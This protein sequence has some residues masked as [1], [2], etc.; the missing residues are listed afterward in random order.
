MEQ[1]GE[2]RLVRKKY[3]DDQVIDV[4]ARLHGRE[5]SVEEIFNIIGEITGQRDKV[6][7]AIAHAYEGVGIS[8]SLRRAE[9]I[10]EDAYLFLLSSE[11]GRSLKEFAQEYGNVKKK[12]RDVK[13]QFLSNIYSPVMALVISL[14]V[15]YIFIYR[16][17]PQMN[18]PKEKALKFLPFYFH[19]IFF[20]SEHIW[21][22]FLLL[23]GVMGL[24]V[25]VYLFRRRIR[26]IEKFYGAYERVKLYSYLFL[27]VKAG[28]RLETALERYRGELKENVL[29]TFR[30][31]NEG[32]PLS[33][34]LLK[35]LKISDPVERTLVK[36]S[37]LSGPAEMG[38]SLGELYLETLDMLT[39]RLSRAGET[40]RLISLL[41]VGLVL[42]FVYGFVFMPLLSA[43]KSIMM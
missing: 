35:A 15:V 41:V 14:V 5:R 26:F 1:A 16:V 32:E 19:F 28:F 10:S 12:L 18:L 29:E 40:V 37:L 4:L 30:Y 39:Q 17:I 34:A 13:K 33:R 27:S 9:L 3:Y 21:V 20:M 38:K 42:V 24:I 36:S 31:M 8:E 23:F 22:Y 43:I 6:Q 11:K 2:F 25:S 7:L